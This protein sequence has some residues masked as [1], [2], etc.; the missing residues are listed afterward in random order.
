MMKNTL[1]FALLSA[2]L[3]LPVAHAAPPVEMQTPTLTQDITSAGRLRLQSQRL[4]KLW[5]QAGLGIHAGAATGQL[6]R[7]V[8][9]FEVNLA[10][11]ARY[12]KKEGTQQ[13]LQRINELWIAY[14]I[15]LSLPYNESNLKTVSYLA[16][17]L[18]QASGKL[19]MKIE[20]NANTGS[21][22]LLDLSLR[23]NMLAQR[24]ARLYLMAQ[25]GDRSHGRLVD[26]D[27]TKKEFATALA[28]LVESRENTLAS[29]EAL[30]LARMQWMFFELAISE[31]SNK[32]VSR[33]QHVATASERILETLDAVSA[34]YAS[35][36]ADAR[37]AAASANTRHN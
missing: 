33:P 9:H 19:T 12:E 3:T 1:A 8:A 21:G 37:F 36:G 35:A 10:S 4:A 27:Q 34:Q 17:D 24:L 25:A 16:D 28:E 26:I 13:P 14:R 15:A 23:Q 7:G 2:A 31:M 32:G 20:A 30:E 22:R 18:T 6:A 29:R 5:L 11:L